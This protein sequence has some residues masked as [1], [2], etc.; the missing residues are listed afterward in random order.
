MNG[1]VVL[2]ATGWERGRGLGG[3]AGM[4]SAEAGESVFRS[5]T[6]AD[7]IPTEMGAVGAGRYRHPRLDSDA[8]AWPRQALACPLT[9]RRIIPSMGLTV[10]RWR[11]PRA[12]GAC[13]L[14]R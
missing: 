4:V 7:V 11:W 8:H 12:L 10:L 9:V 2:R 13:T 1:V 14:V 5:H 3:R 6:G